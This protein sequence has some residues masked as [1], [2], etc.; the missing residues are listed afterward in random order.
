[1]KKSKVVQVS[2]D[3]AK[4][5]ASS[6]APKEKDHEKSESD[7]EREAEIDLDDLLRAEKIKADPERM[8]RILAAAD[9]KAGSIRSIQDLKVAGEALAHKNR[10]PKREK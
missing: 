9:K 5:P 2:S 4:T 10:F 8:K 7:F 6:M 1:M 3:F